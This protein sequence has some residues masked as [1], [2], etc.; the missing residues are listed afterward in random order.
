MW[1]YLPFT[2][3][4]AL[5]RASSKTSSVKSSDSSSVAGTTFRGGPITVTFASTYSISL[6]GFTFVMFLPP[7]RLCRTVPSFQHSQQKSGSCSLPLV[8]KGHLSRGRSHESPSGFPDDETL[9]PLPYL[10]TS[11]SKH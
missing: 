3:R 5:S 4:L 8:R 2:G 7:L 9:A 6:L 10:E 11:S 1:A